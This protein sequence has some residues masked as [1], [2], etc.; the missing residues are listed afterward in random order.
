MMIF[1]KYII[2]ESLSLRITDDDGII[3]YYNNNG[4]IITDIHYLM[5]YY[6]LVIIDNC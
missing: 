5:I 1:Y 6:D 3:I 2:I 4:I